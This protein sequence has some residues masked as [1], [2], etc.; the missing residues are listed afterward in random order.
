MAKSGKK[1]RIGLRVAGVILLLA[2]AA[3]GVLWY[4]DYRERPKLVDGIEYQIP[5]GE[6]YAQVVGCDKEAASLIIQP[7]YE[8]KPVAEILIGAF[9]NAKAETIEIPSTVITVYDSAFAG[10]GIRISG[11][12]YGSV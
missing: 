12:F 1:K 6:G 3:V 4:L 2:A 8:G 7:E 11:F 9:Y 5:Q 10:S